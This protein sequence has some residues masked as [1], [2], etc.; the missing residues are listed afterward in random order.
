MKTLNATEVQ[1]EAFTTEFIY[2]SETH[3]CEHGHIGCSTVEGGY[4]FDEA[5]AMLREFRLD[6]GEEVTT[7]AD[8]LVGNE[9]DVIGGL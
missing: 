6:R 3:N 9:T 8:E 1:L 7:V 2:A 5:V 4:C